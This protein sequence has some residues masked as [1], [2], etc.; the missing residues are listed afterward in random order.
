MAIIKFA[1]RRNLIYPLQDMIWNLVRNLLTMFIKYLFDFKDSL[2]YTPLMFFGELSGGGIIYLYQKKYLYAKKNEEKEQY[3]MS[4]KLLS[5]KEDEDD[6]FIPVDNNCKILFL[7]F[8]S[9]FCDQT[10]FFFENSITPKYNKLSS[11]IFL[12]LG[13]FSALFMLIF[14]LYALK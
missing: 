5:N 12:R 10:Q 8:L 3:F 6:Y 7:M 14:Y 4:I 13:G 2:L 9:A 11:S 1:L